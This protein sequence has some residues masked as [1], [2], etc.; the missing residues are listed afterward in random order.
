MIPRP[1]LTAAAGNYQ[2]PRP[3]TTTANI[4]AA[5]L[6]IT[7]VTNTKVY[8]GTTSAAAIPTVSG[9]KGSDTVTNLTET[10]ATATVGTGITLNVA[11]YTVNDGNSGNNYA[12]SLVSN[13]T[14][15]ITAATPTATFINEDTTT[16]GNWIGKYGSLG[17]DFIDRRRAASLGRHGHAAGESS[18]T[19]ANPR[20][21][22]R[23]RRSRFRPAERPASP[24]AGI[25][26][27][28]SRWM[29][30]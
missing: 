15:V 3:A 17:Y 2:L 22:P 19:W 9:L 4:T 26:R 20:P 1:E 12:V 18:Y 24:R 14:G 27:R 29:W 13:N 8:D 25:R 11:T 6:T 7:A 28:A 16:Q 30:M 5:P 23:R 10:Y 21:R